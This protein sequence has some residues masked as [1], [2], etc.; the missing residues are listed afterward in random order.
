VDLFIVSRLPF[1]RVYNNLSKVILERNEETIEEFET[2]NCYTG[3]LSRHRC[4][5]QGG[6]SGKRSRAGRE[7]ERE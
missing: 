7:R 5:F 6:V 1:L 2:V 3:N 4:L